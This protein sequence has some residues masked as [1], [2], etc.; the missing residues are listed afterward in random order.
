MMREQPIRLKVCG[1]R[2]AENIMAVAALQPDYMGFIF[3]DKSPRFVGADFLVPAGFPAAVKRVGVFVNAP[4]HEIISLVA[5]HGLH[6]VQL[7]GNEPIVQIAALHAAGIKTFKVFSIDA[8]FDFEVVKPFEEYADYFLFDT[9]GKFYGGNAQTFDWTLLEKYDQHVPFFLSGGLTV[10]NIGE[11]DE[12][13]RMNLHGLD[14]NSGVES[15]PALKDPE[16]V[17][18]V[19]ESISI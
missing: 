11:I 6:F 13:R 2:D 4:T 5:R 1:M 8:N 12:L 3:Y 18:K 15:G 14:F 16:K 17:R 7:H 19:I 9:K 10:D